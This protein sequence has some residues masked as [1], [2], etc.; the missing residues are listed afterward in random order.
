MRYLLGIVT[1]DLQHVY[2]NETS[3]HDVILSGYFGSI[4]LYEQD[5]ITSQ[6]KKKTEE[7]LELLEIENLKNNK[8]NEMSYG[9]A[10]RFLIGRALIHSPKVLI[11]DEPTNSL[12]MRAA[13][14]FREIMRKI[15]RSGASIIL[16]THNIHDIIPEIT[17]VAA[18][19]DG[20]FIADGKKEEIITGKI[21][22]ELFDISSGIE[23][24]AGY[25]YVY[26]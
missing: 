13:N 4:G 19:R 11:L 10:K 8:I 3:G 21:I 18:M 24:R 20:R 16:V 26:N 5:K 1:N 9:E 15:A 23:N 12:D 25:Y 14:K 22:S 2:M 7:V 17:R 6:M